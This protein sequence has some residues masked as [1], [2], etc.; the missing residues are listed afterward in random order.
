MRVK[1]IIALVLGVIA[2]GITLMATRAWYKKW[3]RQKEA[4]NGD[5]NKKV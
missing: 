1:G 4:Q 5:G 3:K 2:L